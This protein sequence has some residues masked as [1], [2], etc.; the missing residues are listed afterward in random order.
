MRA[1]LI[2]F[3]DE[4]YDESK[5]LLLFDPIATWK[6]TKLEGG[7]Y[8]MRELL[9]PIFRNGECI[10]TSPTV[11]EIASYCKRE[12]ETLWDET[13]RLANPHRVYVDLSQKL[14]DEKQALLNK[15][16]VE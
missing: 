13:M 15:V 7:S 11:M 14:F 2:C 3:A 4:T 6:K 16:S 5:D 10:Y 1:D 8:T 12:K 9:Q